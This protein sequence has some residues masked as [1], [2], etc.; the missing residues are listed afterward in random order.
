MR[1]G[2]LK[3]ETESLL[4]TAQ[5]QAIRTNS[6]K[7]SI[8]K[9]SETPRCRLWNENIASVTHIISACP[10]LAKNQYRKRHD[11]VAKKIHWLLCKNFHLEYNDKWYEHVLIQCSRMNDVKS[12]R[13]FLSKLTRLLNIDNLILYASTNK[14]LLNH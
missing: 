9:T 13:I 8:D 3:R 6:V 1:K 5:D 12:C 14:N 10:N 11:K 2:E 7:H 4:C